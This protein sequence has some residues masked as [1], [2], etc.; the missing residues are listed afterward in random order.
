MFKV[1]FVPNLTTL[2]L[3]IR[4]GVQITNPYRH[5]AL[6]PLQGL[7]HYVYSTSPFVCH[8]VWFLRNRDDVWESKFYHYLFLPTFRH[9]EKGVKSRKPC[10]AQYRESIRLWWRFIVRCRLF[11]LTNQPI[12][13]ESLT[14]KT[15]HLFGEN[16]TRNYIL[17]SYIRI[18]ISMIYV[19]LIK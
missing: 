12:P 16:T 15:S 18:N 3:L 7:F 6:N 14:Y 8:K 9:F 2:V 11:L 19:V 17:Y 4:Q 5:I 10:S 1:H 13:N